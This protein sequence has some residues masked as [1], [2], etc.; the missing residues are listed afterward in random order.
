MN[1][2]Y[3]QHVPFEGLGSI[4]GVLHASGH[5]V[6]R[7]RLF[8]DEPL[9]EVAEVDWLI[10]MG[11][12]MGIYD[13]HR[14]NWLTREK[15]FIEQICSAGKKVL[16]I[17]LGA[18]LIADVLGSRVYK[19]RFR[20]IGWFHVQRGAESIS[21][22]IGPAFSKEMEVFHWHGDTFDLPEK[23]I[24]IGS[25]EAC[26]NQGFIVD[27]RIVGLQF[28]LEATLETVSALLE[29]CS[30]ELDNSRYVQTAEQ[31]LSDPTRFERSN[32]VMEKIV[33]LLQ[34]N[35]SPELSGDA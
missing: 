14:F 2:H 23:S 19:N 5:T 12:P 7:T 3:L 21:T 4:K 20:E 30:D 29:N 16:G 8:A 15:K 17:C 31:I 26:L 1:V 6:G 33:H 22:C 10:I 27:D 32:R 11:G 9:P 13:D 35:R 34:R 24:R 18:Q 25:S 28:H